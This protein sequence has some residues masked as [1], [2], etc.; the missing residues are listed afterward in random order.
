[1]KRAIVTGASSG[2]GLA[3]AKRLLSLDFYVVGIARDFGKCD[4]KSNN[5]QAIEFDLTQ[6]SKLKELK[7]A[8]G[9]DID[10][11]VNC[12]GVGEFKPL[13][14]MQIS[15]IE[16]IVN[17]NLLAPITLTNL[18]LRDLKKSRGYIFNITSIEA[19]KHSKFSSVYTATKSGLRD[20]SLSLF[21]EV[22]KSGVKVVSINPDMTKTDFFNEF[23]FKEGKAED[24]HLKPS[25][26]ADVIED[27]LSLRDGTVITDITVRP[28]RFGIEKKAKR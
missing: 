7:K 26:I 28:Q 3:V 10:I 20:F 21:E 22:R 27:I 16:Q 18:F 12:A 6:I 14:E 13:E 17:T 4:I 25:C 23:S 11:L 24:T 5:F 1:M 2:I 8:I 19:L 15:K 9:S